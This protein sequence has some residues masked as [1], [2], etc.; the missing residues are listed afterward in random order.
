MALGKGLNSLLPSSS[1]R[2]MV[3]HETGIV[4]GQDKIW[5]IPLSEISPNPE[6]PRK[7]FSHSELENLVNSIKQHG[8]I[9]PLVVSE[10]DDG[11][12]ELIAGERR[13]RSAQIVGLPTVPTIVRSAT[14]QEKLELALIENIQRQNLN[15]LEEAFAFQRLVDEFNLTQ[16][17]VGIRVGKNRST[18]ANMLRLLELPEVA[19]KALVDA[20][21]SVGQAKALLSLNNEKEQ[22]EILQSMLGEKMSVREV[23]AR[24]AKKPLSSRKG[25]VRRDPNIMASERLLEERLGTKV[26]ITTKG[27]RGTI[28]I[29]YY[30]AEELKRLLRDLS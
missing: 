17:E 10:K 11:G 22:I 30:S 18:I 29:E 6:Q 14:Q 4:S 20:K 5:Q 9:Q 1:A 21:I 3:R 25:S 15:P 23:E 12:Y 19:Q 2:R 8:I 26:H 24:I 28:V 16:E 7:D 13:L 27:D